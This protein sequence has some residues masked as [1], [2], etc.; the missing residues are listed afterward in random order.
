MCTY[1]EWTTDIKVDSYDVLDHDHLE[2]MAREDRRHAT[3]H[4]QAF[5]DA[6][7]GA[8][9]DI[10][11]INGRTMISAFESDEPEQTEH[12]WWKSFVAASSCDDAEWRM[13]DLLALLDNLAR[14]GRQG[15][16]GINFSAG[17]CAL[18]DGSR[19]RMA[20]WE[21]MVE[22]VND[23]LATLESATTCAT[24]FLTIQS[25]SHT[26]PLTAGWMRDLKRGLTVALDVVRI[27]RMS[28][29]TATE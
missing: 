23:H 10:D 7:I 21:Q 24:G 6:V 11:R 9:T 16:T 5:I 26:L 25:S 15:I 3:E 20:R 4:L 13:D 28:R 17:T 1:L 14:I 18:P 29:H 2:S 27:S 8:D 19:V 22:P 12:D